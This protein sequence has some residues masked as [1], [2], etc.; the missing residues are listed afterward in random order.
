[1]NWDVTKTEIVK[2]LVCVYVMNVKETKTVEKREILS[3]NLT[4]N[5]EGIF[6]SMC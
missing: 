2:S 6:E 1:M 3:Q 4:F 5:L